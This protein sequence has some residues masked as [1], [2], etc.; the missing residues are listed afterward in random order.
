[1]YGC[2]GRSGQQW[3]EDD[4]TRGRSGLDASD[5]LALLAHMYQPNFSCT[6]TRRQ[7]ALEQSVIQETMACPCVHWISNGC[8]EGSMS[9]RGP[10]TLKILCVQPRLGMQNTHTVRS[11]WIPPAS[12]NRIPS[13]AHHLIQAKSRPPKKNPYSDSPQGGLSALHSLEIACK[14]LAH[15][16]GELV[17]KYAI[18]R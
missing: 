7:V 14:D 6:P 11:Q 10:G 13:L 1:M 9:A 15:H 2:H 3:P 5:S 8:R 12:Q 4:L 16:A 17:G 18:A